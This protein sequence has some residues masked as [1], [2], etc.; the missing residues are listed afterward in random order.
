MAT[1]GRTGM[2]RAILGSVADYVVSQIKGAAVLLVRPEA[3]ETHE[4]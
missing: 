1:H 2:R 3:E 4:G